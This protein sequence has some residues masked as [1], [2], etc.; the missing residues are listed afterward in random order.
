[1]LYE[2]ITSHV[3][4]TDGTSV[5]R[6]RLHWPRETRVMTATVMRPPGPWRSSFAAW[7]KD[8]VAEHGLDEYGRKIGAEFR[9]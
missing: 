2:V 1:M 8:Y 3:V 7:Y 4:A 5:G 9:K 6:K